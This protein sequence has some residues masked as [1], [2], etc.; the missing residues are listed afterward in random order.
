M[1]RLGGFRTIY[2]SDLRRLV[3]VTAASGGRAGRTRDGRGKRFAAKFAANPVFT[4]NEFKH[5][6]QICSRCN[7]RA[8]LNDVGRFDTEPALSPQPPIIIFPRRSFKW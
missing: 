1:L 8:H 4:Q 6:T 3:L 5:I 7:A 2:S